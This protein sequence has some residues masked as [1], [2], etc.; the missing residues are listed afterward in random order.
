MPRRA[1]RQ[2]CCCKV[3]MAFL[4]MTMANEYDVIQRWEVKTLEPID[5]IEKDSSPR[6]HLDICQVACLPEWPPHNSMP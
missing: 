1:A 5:Y 6:Q 2:Y 4:T 3:Q